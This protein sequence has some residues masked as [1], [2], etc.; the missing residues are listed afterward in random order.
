MR[1]DADVEGCTGVVLLARDLLSP[2][3]LA[4]LTARFSAREVEYVARV[5]TPEELA[6]IG[7]LSDALIIA[8]IKRMPERRLRQFDQLIPH[9][10]DHQLYRTLQMQWLRDEEYLLGTQLGRRP[11][12]KE[13]FLDFMNHHNGLRFR[14]YFS[15][16]YPDRV[17]AVRR[18]TVGAAG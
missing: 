2:A 10:G 9:D 16:K 13:L 18:R 12:H 6:V 7:D 3:L 17:R 4:G 8:R 11:T 1:A 15:M 14:A 5:L